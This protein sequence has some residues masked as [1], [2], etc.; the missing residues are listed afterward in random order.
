MSTLYTPALSPDADAVEIEA[1]ISWVE[2]LIDQLDT[3]SVTYTV[4]LAFYEDSITKLVN[5]WNQLQEKNSYNGGHQGTGFAP[6]PLPASPG[7]SGGSASP[8]MGGSH[9][10]QSSPAEPTQP[11]AR[12]RSLGMLAGIDRDSKR[13]SLTASPALTPGTPASVNLPSPA[14]RGDS[15]SHLPGM[16]NLSLAGELNPPRLSPAWLASA[17]LHFT[18]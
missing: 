5:R 2:Q 8:Y 11:F 3:N 1:E 10:A 15:R 17:H 18:G 4:D 14:F 9:S 6:P 13:P 7:L 16:Q 12:K